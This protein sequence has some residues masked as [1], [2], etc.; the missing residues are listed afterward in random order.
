MRARVNGELWS[1]ATLGNM[2]FS[3]AQVISHLSQE[4][5]LQ[6]GDVL[7]SGTVAR[8]CGLELDRWIQQGDIVELQVDGI[9]VLRNPVGAKNHPPGPG[10]GIDSILAPATPQMNTQPGKRRRR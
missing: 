4:Q 2:Q 7:G 3:F 8:G 5:T 10:A 6:P 9:G 1:E